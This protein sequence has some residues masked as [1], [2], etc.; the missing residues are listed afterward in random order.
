MEVESLLLWLN[1]Y[2]GLRKNLSWIKEKKTLI[3][4]VQV[5]DYRLRLREIMNLNHIMLYAKEI[6]VFQ[7]T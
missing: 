3:N 5:Y 1:F 4:Q 6:V 7:L 2:R